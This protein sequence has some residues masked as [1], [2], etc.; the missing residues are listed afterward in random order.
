MIQ[1]MT[2]FG[3]SIINIDNKKVTV[4]VKSL[5]SKQLDLAVKMPMLFRSIELD[6]RNMIAE[7]LGRG[8]VELFITVES[9]AGTAASINTQALKNYKSQIETLSA[10]L[11][12]P[13][14]DDWY[15]TLLRLPDALQS[16]NNS[17]EISD[18]TLKAIKETTRTA[19]DALIEFRAQ[20][21]HKLQRFFDQKI[22]DIQL[23]LN[24]VPEYENTRVDKIR[25]RLQAS[26]EKIGDIEYDK[27]RFEQE[28][29]F[30][31]EKL[32][33]TEEKTRLQNHLHYFTDTM[34]NGDQQGKKLGFI[35]QEMGREINTMGSKANQAELQRIVV[36][37]KDHLEQIKEQVLN[38]L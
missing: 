33:I 28:L 5:N 7:K 38:V 23:L 2:G 27:N 4:E 14:P 20:E 30:Y 3:K 21:G 1:S 6:L 8:K 25:E 37:M 36:M 19:I 32:D 17:N 16:D 24:K 22:E 9:I 26:L 29:I 31:I 11:N 15:A 10:E 35:A 13:L 12:I 18:E 34:A